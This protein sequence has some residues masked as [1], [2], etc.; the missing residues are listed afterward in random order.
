MRHLIPAILIA[1]AACAGRSAP[2][3]DGA[4]SPAPSTRVMADLITE[5]EISKTAYSNAL[6]IVQSLRPNMLRVRPTTLTPTRDPTG[7]PDVAASNAGVVAYFD[8]VRL[9][10]VSQLSTIP[11]LRILEIRYI[12]SRDATTRW[13]TGHGA[14]VIQVISR[15][16]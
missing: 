8:E 3:A 1:T 9:G 10:E 7:F 12:N 16:Q 6:E 13:G 14:G 11:T 15:K 4:P 5:A 2:P